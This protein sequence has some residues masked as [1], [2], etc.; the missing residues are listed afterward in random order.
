MLHAMPQPQKSAAEVHSEIVAALAELEIAV[1]PLGAPV[2]AV[3]GEPGSGNSSWLTMNLSVGTNRTRMRAAVLRLLD[4]PLR[5]FR[6][7]AVDRS[8]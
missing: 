8:G 2:I 5:E 7:D 1:R 3:I 6:T 4:R